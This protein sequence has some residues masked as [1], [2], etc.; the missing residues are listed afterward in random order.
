MLW[1]S[2]MQWVWCLNICSIF[3]T[4]N[5]RT[6]QA[7]KPSASE[8]MPSLDSHVHLLCLA[9]LLLSFIWKSQ[10]LGMSFPTLQCT[11]L[12]WGA[13]PKLIWL[14]IGLLPQP[15]PQ[16]LLPGVSASLVQLLISLLSVLDF[17]KLTDF[18]QEAFPDPSLISILPLF[19][20]TAISTFLQ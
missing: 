8:L 6:R 16:S 19:L 17:S 1:G 2:G 12:H 4:P 20:F 5:S 9:C 15:S 3:R 14:D 11:L 18:L 7:H 10:G 13:V